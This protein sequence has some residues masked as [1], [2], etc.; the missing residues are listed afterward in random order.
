MMT[1]QIPFNTVKAITDT[2]T[3]LI[4]CL[5]S[6]ADPEFLLP[7]HLRMWCERNS[8]RGKVLYRYEGTV[9]YGNGETAGVGTGSCWRNGDDLIEPYCVLQAGPEE[10]QDSEHIPF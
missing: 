3:V 4:H 10:S 2:N 5:I 1:P 8:V 6:G 9:R 7:Y